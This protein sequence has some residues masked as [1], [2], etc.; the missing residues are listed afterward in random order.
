MDLFKKNITSE[1]IKLL[2]VMQF[3]GNIHIIDNPL[4]LKA[5]LKKL[6]NEK[7]I[8]FDTET[9]PN[10][11]KGVKNLNPIALLQLSGINDSYLFR[12]NKLGLPSELAG[13]LSRKSITKVGVAVRDDIRIL[14]NILKFNPGGFIDLSVFSKKYE[15]EA[16]GLKKL[17]AIV[18]G[19]RISKSQQL[20]NWETETLSTAQEIYASTDSW[21]CL[22]I[23]NKLINTIYE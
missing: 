20:S 17:A 4:Q 15:I 13:I 18:L 9:K 6:R 2:P 12:I 1:E 5:A 22:M 14:N 11:K 19:H 16:N 21:V 8:G 23:Y 10:F 3:T 7:I